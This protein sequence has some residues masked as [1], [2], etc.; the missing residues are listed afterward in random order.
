MLTA[1]TALWDDCP[2]E[3][4]DCE[5]PGDCGKYIDTNKDSICDHSQPSVQETQIK[6][7]EQEETISA[8]LGKS[9]YFLPV[10]VITTI[11]YLITYTLQ[12]KKII[13]LFSEDGQ[14]NKVY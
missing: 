9:Y 3:Q 7:E 6:A 12:K 10:V 1:A 4:V 14:D 13:T 8:Q 11:L 2:N 5:Y